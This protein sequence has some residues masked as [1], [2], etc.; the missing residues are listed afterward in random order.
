ML[1]RPLGC[2]WVLTWCC[3][4]GWRLDEILLSTLH[5]SVGSGGDGRRRRR[6]LRLRNLRQPR[7][8]QSRL[9]AGRLEVRACRPRSSSTHRA[10]PPHHG[11]RSTRRVAA[12]SAAR[13]ARVRAEGRASPCA[14]GWA[15]A[16]DGGADPREHLASLPHPSRPHPCHA[17]E[18]T[19]REHA[20]DEDAGTPGLTRM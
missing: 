14:L 20:R 10:A 6:R 11:R 17:R 3:S 13:G 16:S 2:L 5:R 8:R 18:S 12:E 4:E 7:R 1:H 19:C 9:A 15:A